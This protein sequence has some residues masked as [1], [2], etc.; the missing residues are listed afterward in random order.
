MERF[1]YET[2][3]ELRNRLEQLITVPRNPT[4]VVQDH[5]SRIRDYSRQ[6]KLGCYTLNNAEFLATGFHDLIC[7]LTAPTNKA[8]TLPFEPMV[9][10]SRTLCYLDDALKWAT[11]GQ[12]SIRNTIVLDSQILRSA[13]FRQ[14]ELPREAQ[15]R[16]GQGFRVIQDICNLLEPRVVLVCNCSRFETDGLLMADLLVSSMAETG[17][18][19]THAW[20]S[21]T[22]VQIVKSFHPEF[23]AKCQ[24]FEQRAL[25]ELLFK[26]TV[27]MAVNLLSGSEVRGPGIA[28]LRKTV[29]EG[30]RMGDQGLGST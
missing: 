27:A 16:N 12:R 10:A 24:L 14:S 23:V 1:A 28:Q 7:I 15:H 11:Q 26:L 6:F 22:K 21:G 4:A 13:H 2:V 25:R 17:K 20:P 19:E 3:E 29:L 8:D 30:T 18:I 9:A 5:L